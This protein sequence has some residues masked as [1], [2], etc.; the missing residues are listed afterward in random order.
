MSKL[1]TLNTKKNG[2]FD[3]YFEDTFMIP[4][5][6]EVA[7]I[8]TLGVNV[9]YE[10]KEFLIPPAI[11]AA[12]YERD[13]LRFCCD[14]VSVV[15][16]WKNLYDAYNIL[17][18]GAAVDI[19]VFLSATFRWTLD[20]LVG[21]N[22]VDSICEALSDKLTFYEIQPNCDIAYD[23][24][25][26]NKS[27][28]TKF[29]VTS[30]YDTSKRLNPSTIDDYLT[31][32]GFLNTYKGEATLLQG[33]LTTTANDTIIYSSSDIALNGGMLSFRVTNDH[34]CK[35]GVSFDNH[36][37]NSV[38]GNVT[39]PYIDF[40]IHVNANGAN[41]YNIIRNNESIPGTQGFS[42]NNETF[43]IIFSRVNQPESSESSD[44]HA[45]LL[46]DYFPG[47][48]G[49]GDYQ[50]Y[51]VARQQL[52]GGYN[53]HFMCDAP[54]SGT[55][56]DNIKIIPA[57]EQDQECRTFMTEVKTSNAGTNIGVGGTTFRNS[58][59]FI[60]VNA[61]S[62]DATERTQTL[63][64]FQ[65]LGLT[66]F[67][68]DLTSRRLEQ[69]E[70]YANEDNNKLV[71][72]TQLRAP[73]E[74]SQILWIPAAEPEDLDNYDPD[75]E[76]RDQLLPEPFPYLQFHM[77]TL[78]TISFEGN[79]FK[80]NKSR[81]QNTATKVLMN[82]PVGTKKTLSEAFGGFPQS[83]ITYDYETFT[84]YYVTLNNPEPIPVNQI[85][86]RLATPKNFIVDFDD[87]DGT[88]DAL[89]MLH[90]RKSLATED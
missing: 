17:Y 65:T 77:E 36:P 48:A 40:G 2:V 14:G 72:Q 73:I 79:Y 32:I 1:I 88:S 84:P 67:T 64:F 9:K 34:E 42:G 86:C 55:V 23:I 28:Y 56:V 44:Y 71:I 29:G 24:N 89:C 62:L 7:L 53:P 22:V 74:M 75:D 59:S 12:N 51:T 66:S 27:T 80:Q 69:F 20:P 10:S 43:Q 68:S 16:S 60:L 35:I 26:G 52:F 76:K 25:F 85:K 31:N 21:G 13:I 3:N 54:N 5:N 37:Q 82:I 4:K 47:G 63:I 81:Q 45:F 50:D 46:Q 61:A 39:D 6:A 49:V 11:E 41:T 70:S 8:K 15:I 30:T 19:D 38:T 83:Y 57:E 33:S 18:E 78:N 87:F 58:H 90:F